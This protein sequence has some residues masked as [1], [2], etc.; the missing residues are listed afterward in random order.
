MMVHAN[1]AGFIFS[2]VKEHLAGIAMFQ[3]TFKGT[4]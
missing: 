3:D 4:W 2:N 1:S